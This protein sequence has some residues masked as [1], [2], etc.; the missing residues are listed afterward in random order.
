MQ[1]NQ[2]V[3]LLAN[4]FTRWLWKDYARYLGDATGLTPLLLV[5][6]EQDRRFYSE[7]YGEPAGFEIVALRNPYLSV[8][9]GNGSERTTSEIVGT[10]RA[11]E[12]EFGFSIMREMVLSDRHLGRGFMLA[13]QG[14]PKSR[15]SEAANFQSTYETCVE[16]FAFTKELF[17]RYPPQLVVS[18]YSGGGIVGKP[19]AAYC[20]KLEVAFRTICPARFGGLAYWAHD[21]FE[22]LPALVE[23]LGLQSTP[24]PDSEIQQIQELIAPSSLAT[25][26]SAVGNLLRTMRY[27]EL[28]KTGI[29]R[30]LQTLYGRWRGY[31]LAI[32]GYRYRS[33]MAQLFRMRR[34]WRLLNRIA[35]KKLP[36]LDDL[37]VVYF[38]LQQEPEAS[39]LVLSPDHTNQLAT[40]VEIAL[41]L[42]P[43]AVLVVKEHLW[44]LGRRSE[45]VF[46]TVQQL[47]NVILVHPG[48]SSLDIIWRADVVC[49]ITSSA[50]YEAAAL[51]K[52]VVFFWRDAPLRNLPHVHRMSRF[53]GLEKI[54]ELLDDDDEASVRQRAND[55]A[56]FYKRLKQHCMDLDEISFYS[57]SD[58]PTDC[59]LKLLSQDLLPFPRAGE[60]VRHAGAA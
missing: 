7:Q 33:V 9:T 38:P 46:R 50:G 58:R 54:R 55:G 42:P 34:H 26:S 57:R 19:I 11:I 24:L 8:V 6:T 21:E 18:Y 52:Q 28:A 16:Q 30:L 10:A 53:E 2:H 12:T 59:E 23:A 13:G 1:K 60:D 4:S 22:G 45:E 44:Q 48:G 27:R 43:N 47:P 40:I 41:T 5:P 35:V 51:G 15:P 17:D 37:K 56:L 39:T 20:R 31:E 25:N 36:P 14:H 3:W 29:K 32:A 49:T